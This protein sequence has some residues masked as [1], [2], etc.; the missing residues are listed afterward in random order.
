MQM[1]SLQPI[2]V[3]KQRKIIT[4]FPKSNTV[5][6]RP[7]KN[8]IQEPVGGRKLDTLHFR[9]FIKNTHNFILLFL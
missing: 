5:T 6:K 9:E 8:K 2:F 4:L 7:S 3:S 1:N